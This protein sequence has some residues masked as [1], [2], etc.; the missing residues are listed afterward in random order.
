MHA[1]CKARRGQRVSRE[2]AVMDGEPN[3]IA[4]AR[5]KIAMRGEESARLIGWRIAKAID[6]MMAVAL[7]MGHPDQGPEREV[8][9]HG[10]PGLAGQ[11]F[12]GDEEFFALSAPFGRAGRVD[13]GLVDSL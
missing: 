13:Y 5:I 2:A 10:E 11:V 12:A 3:L 7:G 1:G 4:G 6:I 8:L 9:L